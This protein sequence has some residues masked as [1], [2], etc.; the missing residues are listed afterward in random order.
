MKIVV[1]LVAVLSFAM[2]VFAQTEQ[3]PAADWD[4]VVDEFFDTYFENN[5]TAA[6]YAGL[7]QYDTKLEDYSRAGVNKEIRWAKDW[8]AR[9]DAFDTSKLNLEQRQDH[10]LVVNTL[11]G[12][13]LELEDIRKWER[14][15]DRYS[16]GITQSAFLIMSRNFAPAD[17]RLRSLIA[18]E[19][20]MP[21]VFK[22]ARQNLKNPPKIYTEVALQQVP[23]IISFFQNDVPKAFTEVKDPKLLAEFKKSN[24][25]VIAALRGYETFLKK[26]VLPRSNGDFRIGP[27]KFR[28]KLLYDEFVDIPLDHLLEIGYADLRKNQQEFK[29]VAALVDPKKT[30]EQILEELQNDHPTGD[31]LL[32][33]FRDVLAGIRSYIVEK[34]ILTIPSPVPPIVQETPPFAR[35]LSSASMD[36]PGPYEK[37]AKEAYFNVTLP[38]KDWSKERT[39]DWLRGFNRGTIISTAIHEAYPGHYTQFLWVPSAPSK[40]RKLL[41]AGSNAEGWAHY[42]EQMMLDEGYGNNDPKLRLGQIID[43]LLRDARFIVGI[44]MHTGDM[45]FEQAKEFFVKEGY[46]SKGTAE[47]ESKRGTSDPTYLIYTLGKLQILKLREDYHKKMGDKFTLQEFHD[48]FLKQGFPPVKFVRETMLGDNSP[49]L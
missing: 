44:S 20:Q 29:R 8:L 2:A 4:R 16:S 32:Q 27:D 6:S 9:F 34:K 39:E 41:G 22:A 3:K 46:Q 28:K 1:A 10:A 13:L 25:A 12:N 14:S 37:V 19:K 26:D 47:Q 42:T 33:S 15:P 23:G 5:P 40:I 21:I 11:K 43:A 24:D 49:V 38:E 48:T 30:P 31:Q 17:E 18:R 45:T 35:A 36:T 7:H